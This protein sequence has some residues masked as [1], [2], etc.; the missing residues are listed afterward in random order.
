MSSVGTCFYLPHLRSVF[1][2][3]VIQIGETLGD[4]E[5]GRSPKKLRSL[6]EVPNVSHVKVHDLSFNMILISSQ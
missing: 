6:I 3:R 2:G 1:L 5:K 4:Q